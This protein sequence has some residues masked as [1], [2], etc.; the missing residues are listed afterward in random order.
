MIKMENPGA[1]I[2]RILLS[3]LEQSAVAVVLVDENDV[4]QFFNRAAERLW[5]YERHEVSGESI[6]TLLPEMALQSYDDGRDGSQRML[7]DA[8]NNQ[9]IRLKRRDGRKR[10]ASLT[11][12]RFELD[13][14]IYVMFMAQDVSAAMLRREQDRLL[15]LAVNHTDYPVMV[16]DAGR[17]IAHV[18]QAFSQVYGFRLDEVMGRDLLSVL[19]SPSMPGDELE[20]FCARP[21]GKACCMAEAMVLYKDQREA[22]VRISSSPAL[23]V[24][25][26]DLYGYS[27]DIVTDV[28]E[29]RQIRELE[30]DVLEALTSNLSFEGLGD[31]LCRRIEAIA[32]GVVVDVCRVEERRIRPWAAPNFPP[33]YTAIWNG[34]EIGEGVASSGTSAYRG[35][36]VIVSDIGSDPLWAA[37]RHLVLP[38][39]VHACWTY[40]VKRRDGEVVGTFSFYFK[41][42]GELNAWLERIAHTCVHL[43]K[44]ALE[45]EENR[46]HMTHLVQFDAL[47]GLP[48][49]DQL[50]LKMDE[51]LSDSP[52]Q[53]IAVF[54]LDLD[55]LRD[56][57]DTLGYAAGD[58]V[59]V[60]M[61]NRLKNGLR[62]GEFLYRSEGDLFFIIAPGYDIRHA[63]LMAEQ[64]QQII[65]E[66][67][68][69]SG[70][71]LSLSVS[72]GI[73]HYPEGGHDR[74]ILLTYAKH[75]MNRARD[76]GGGGWQF[77]APEMN[78]IA[79]ERLLLGAALKRAIAAGD[80]RLQYQPQICLQSGRLYGV[81]ALARWYDPQFGVVPPDKF[82]RL[83]EEIGKID[84]I[85]RWALRE[86]CRQMAGWRNDQLA[87]PQVSVNLSPFNFRHRDLPDFVDGVLR[88]HR[89]PGQCLTIEITEST[90]M[91]LTDDMLEV[92]HRIRALGVGL[93][94]DDFG[95]GFS[96]LSNLANLPV[97]EVKI[98][99]SFIDK[100]L[101]ENRQQALV[102]AVIGIG[103]S[104]DL[105]VVAEGVETEEQRR[106]LANL[107][108][109]V[110]QGYL[111]SC[112]LTPQALAKWVK[113]A[114]TDTAS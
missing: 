88:E 102:T 65:G 74:D 58:L 107:R 104:L 95:T 24:K 22:W 40:P 14:C 2:H 31:Y 81:E 59:M 28:T 60:T 35:E 38:L 16:F 25:L 20:Q 46:Q 103:R 50:Y 11:L 45:R 96:S 49:R 41:P 82:I 53:E 97:T 78:M 54:C 18:N 84:A 109:P 56:I 66:P 64:I 1:D 12:N 110:G 52:E 99:R 87:V 77:F 17:R 63:S 21:W 7:D 67:I 33:G 79:R 47:T 27:V 108:C 75:A 61:A 76:A 80:L 93:S 90:M 8:A 4:V 101:K 39:G 13:N 42:G 36:P 57:N 71:S 86:A 111:F 69:V 6:R 5:G 26:A 114:I 106:L 68:D 51:Q 113:A 105:A 32:P 29:E 70:H 48:N 72:I 62:S 3:A 89:L 19:I 112:A 30:R 92:V 100:C 15:L 23:D 43:C 9:T 10:W 44:L 91:A 73:S 34:V 98:D 85:G 37:W 55:R 94:V 83:A